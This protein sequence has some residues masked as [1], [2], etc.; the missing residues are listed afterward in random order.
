MA[1]ELPT[2]DGPYTVVYKFTLWVRVIRGS[3]IWA[4]YHPLTL[5]IGNCK[6][7]FAKTLNRIELPTVDPGWSCRQGSGLLLLTADVEKIAELA[8]LKFGS[9][10]FSSNR[11]DASDKLKMTPSPTLSEEIYCYRKPGSEIRKPCSRY[12]LLPG[13]WFRDL[14]SWSR[15]KFLWCLYTLQLIRLNYIILNCFYKP[16]S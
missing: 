13:A 7:F 4:S 9:N 2:A 3:K 11:Y 5:K 16:L 10:W 6:V 14:I 8:S 15:D 1:I 12:A